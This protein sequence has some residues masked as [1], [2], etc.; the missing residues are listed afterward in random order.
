MIRKIILFFVLILSLQVN[1]QDIHFSQ[2]GQTPLWVNPAITGL[3]DGWER[4]TINHRNQWLNSQTQFMTT[5]ISADLNFFK[6]Q[7]N[8]NAYIGVGMFLWNDVG[9]DSRLGTRQGHISLSGILPIGGGHTLSAGLMGGIGNRSGDMSELVFEDQWDG[10][11]FDPTLASNEGNILKSNIY[12]DFALGVNYLYDGSKN[13]FSGNDAFKFQI[14][15]SM[16][17]VNKPNIKYFGVETE[18][19]FMKF[20]AHTSI[21]KEFESSDFAIEASALQ[22]IQGPHY[23]TMLGTTFLISMKEA[24]KITS[25]NKKSYIGFGLYTRMMDAI[26]PTFRIDFFGFTFGI[27]YDITISQLRQ[28]HGGG[29]LEFS[30]TYRNLGVPL[31]SKN[32]Y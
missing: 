29:S 30:L 11:A 10:E 16:Y 6:T 23:Q 19:L 18:P 12:G 32:G 14:G 17:H 5:G 1:G 13:N 4:V 22:F 8:D 15:A 26:I 2:T 28:S 25:F 21:F 9:G 20:V 7:R 3:F 27:S 31:F 24:S